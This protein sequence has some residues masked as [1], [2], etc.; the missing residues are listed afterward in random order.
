MSSQ[1]KP[2][3]TRARQPRQYKDGKSPA[4]WTGAVIAAIGCV[5]AAIGAMAGPNW[6]VC[7]IGGGLIVAALIVGGILKA[8]GLGQTY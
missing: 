1:A 6:V 8:M 4:A 5:L 2:A 7:I 3:T